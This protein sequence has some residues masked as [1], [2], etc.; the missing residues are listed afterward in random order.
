MNG[1]VLQL[2][3]SVGGI[4]AMVAL[5]WALFGYATAPLTDGG[6]LAEKM[7]RDIPGFRAG[8]IALSRD[9][10]TALVEDLRDNSIYL[11]TMRGDGLVT[12]KLSRSVG[13]A[14]DGEKLSLR[15][16][17]FTLKRADLDLADAEAW[18]IKLKSFAA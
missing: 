17:D 16:R 1:Q 6:A 2:L 11:A 3:I 8:R 13:V 12:R 9:T 15:F 5:C 18:E 10:Q 4:A 7:G 14:R